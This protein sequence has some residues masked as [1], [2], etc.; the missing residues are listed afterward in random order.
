MNHSMQT[1]LEHAC[2][3]ADFHELT[4]TWGGSCVAPVPGQFLTIRCAETFDPLLRRPFAFSSYKPT[5]GTAT[6]IYLKRGHA[7]ALLQGK[8]PGE[9]VD[10]IG[11]L[12]KGFPLPSAGK[13]PILI[14]GGIGIGPV[15]FFATRLSDQGFRPLLVLGTRDK[16]HIPSITIPHGIDFVVCTEEGSHGFHG[17]CTEF[18]ASLDKR[19]FAQSELYCCG[20][21]GMLKACHNLA[22]ERSIPCWVSMEQ[23]MACGVGACMGCAV[24]TT[25]EKAYARVCCEG[26]VFP[27]GSILWN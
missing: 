16:A 18:V 27:S 14:A 26:P 8:V 13:T 15:L 24:R 17:T 21:E 9:S 1:I 2:L 20:P 10:I 25:G 11:P 12:G 6:V 19:I 3:G 5:Q 7:T 4:F 22:S 23:I